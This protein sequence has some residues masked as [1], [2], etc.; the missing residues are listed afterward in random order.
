AED[1]IDGRHEVAGERWLVHHFGPEVTEP[2]RLHVA[3]KRYLCAV[4]AAYREQ[5]SP[6][7]QKSLALQGGPFS[8]DEVTAFER[9]PFHVEAVRLRHWDD[10]AKVPGWAVP[11]LEH[12][13]SR[14]ERT[15][16]AHSGPS[17]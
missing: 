6:A 9:L 3:A 7:S 11:G 1:G 16:S 5:L 13:R 2:I 4:D 14:L 10:Q 15:L 8:A 17:P 12:Y